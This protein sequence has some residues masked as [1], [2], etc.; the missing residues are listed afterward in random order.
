MKIPILRIPYT[1]ESVREVESGIAAVL[2]SGQFAAGKYVAEFEERFA[3]FCGA[4]YAI[5]THSGTSALEIILR[6]I[7][8][9][10]ASV[11]V[12]TNTFIATAFAAISAGA[13]VI[14]ADCDPEDLSLDADDLE[15]KLEPDTRAVMLVHIG[16]IVSGKLEAIREIC[17]RRGIHLVEDCAH[18]HGCRWNGASAGTLG[19][20][21]AFSFF[22]T[23]VMTCGEGGMITTADEGL[24]RE[25]AMLRNHGKNPQRASAI[26]GFGYNWRMS[27]FNAVVGVEQMKRA[28]QIISERQSIARFYDRHLKGIPGLRVVPLPLGVES[29]YY[30]YVAYLDSSIDRNAFKKTLREEFEVQLTGEVYATLCHQ[31]PVWERTC[32][33]GRQRN[34]RAARACCRTPFRGAS[35]PGAEQ[36]ATRHI[37]PPLYP[38]LSQAELEYVAAS[39]E[40]ALTQTAGLGKEHAAVS[41]S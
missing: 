4:R 14:F 34:P 39:L 21:G 6:A 23:K 11:I 17:A 12:P 41:G 29:T 7:G 22:P 3:E 5:A 1:D 15:R 27:E 28:H 25:A 30:K 32:Y 9:Q 31:E 20:A 26:T 10:D 40:Q 37:C 38:G 2:R 36:I 16:G 18:A 19:T 24:Y 35:F 13:R 33:C 8:V